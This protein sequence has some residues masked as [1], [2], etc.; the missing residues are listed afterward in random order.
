MKNVIQDTDCRGFIPHGVMAEWDLVR[1]F[2]RDMMQVVKR[3]FF[4]VQKPEAVRRS[5]DI[6][7][8][9]SQDEATLLLGGTT[10]LFAGGEDATP[11]DSIAMAG[12][13]MHFLGGGPKNLE[14]T[15]IISPSH[16]QNFFISNLGMLCKGH[17]TLRSAAINLDKIVKTSEKRFIDLFRSYR[18]HLSPNGLEE[19][20]QT[21]LHTPNNIC[22]VLWQGWLGMLAY[23]NSCRVRRLGIE[24]TEEWVQFVLAQDSYLLPVR[25]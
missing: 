6:I 18:V 25:C 22:L 12:Y 5:L 19:E 3:M 14:F 11:E 24:A 16:I 1:R 21:L 15:A 9:K 13:L 20:L 2:G 4:A 23:Y 8:K 7:L 17:S 10:A